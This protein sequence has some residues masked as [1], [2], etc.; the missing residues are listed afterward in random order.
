VTV[1][2]FVH[3]G[4]QAGVAGHL[5]VGQGARIG[6]QAGV[7]ADVPAGATLVGSPAQPRQEVFR[8]IAALKRMA[9]QRR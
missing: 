1:E 5:C 9:R 6:A 7:M 8:Q 3:L 2:D 4:G